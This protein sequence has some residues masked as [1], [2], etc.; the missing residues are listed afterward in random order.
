MAGTPWRS[1]RWVQFGIP[2]ARGRQW[3]WHTALQHLTPLWSIGRQSSADQLRLEPWSPGWPHMQGHMDQ[4]QMDSDGSPLLPG[5]PLVLFP[6]AQVHSTQKTPENWTF[7]ETIWEDSF[8]SY[9]CPNA[10]LTIL[11]PHVPETFG[12]KFVNIAQNSLEE[13]SCWNRPDGN[14][15]TKEPKTAP[16]I[17]V[18]VTVFEHIS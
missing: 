9:V 2:R 7:Q 6:M 14:L 12:K 10:W 17:F 11:H 13:T 15:K 4:N 3:P 1:A 16:N 18:Q 8:M 5:L